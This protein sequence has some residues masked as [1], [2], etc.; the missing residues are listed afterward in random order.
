ME[1]SLTRQP[2]QEGASGGNS[3]KGCMFKETKDETFLRSHSVTAKCNSCQ[4]TGPTHVDQACDTLNFLFAY[5]CG[6]YWFC[7]SAMKTKD[8]NCKNALHKCSS[9]QAT[10]GTY[11]AC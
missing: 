7:Y 5:C 9:C 6:S 4:A 11:N 10:I 8:F 2:A 1:W 3:V